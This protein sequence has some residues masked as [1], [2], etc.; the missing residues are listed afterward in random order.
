M[1]KESTLVFTFGFFVLS[2][3]VSLMSEL[4]LCC[5]N[6][7]LADA[8]NLMAKNYQLNVSRHQIHRN[9]ESSISQCVFFVVLNFVFLQCISSVTVRK[10][11]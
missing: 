11:R 8:A 6:L 1:A 2:E 10:T 3:C 9:G 4:N 5:L 7:Y